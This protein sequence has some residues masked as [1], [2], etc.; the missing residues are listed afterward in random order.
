MTIDYQSI[1]YD[2]IYATLG[3]PIVL[4]TVGD[5]EKSVTVLNLT[6]PSSFSG[7]G[8]DFQAFQPSVK[9]RMSELSDISPQTDL[10]GGELSMDGKSWRIKSYEYNASPNGNSDGELRLLLANA[11]EP[12]PTI[13]FAVNSVNEGTSNGTILGTATISGSY[14]GIPVWS[15]S[16]AGTTFAI[17]SATGA[18]TVLDNADLDANTHP[19]IAVTIST[20]G[21]TPDASDLNFTVTVLAILPPFGGPLYQQLF[22]A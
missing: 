16:D 21:I 10:V 9:I 14:V 20:T 13:R 2:P 19:T 11:A 5:E 22:A 18:V 15:I 7:F 17:N 6:K 1:L 3:I 4:T 12:I 8:V